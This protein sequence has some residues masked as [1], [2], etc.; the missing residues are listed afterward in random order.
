MNFFEVFWL[1]LVE[2]VT[3][4]LPVSSTGH[5][6]LLSSFFGIQE[7]GFV[8]AFNI[9]IQFGAILAVV[10]LYWRRFLPIRWQFYKKLVIAVLPAVVI[11]FVFKNQVDDLL[12]SS[13]L[14]AVTFIL[15][16][17]VLIW[18]DSK[19]KDDHNNQLQIDDLHWKQ[20][21]ILGFVQCLAMIPGTSRSGATIIGGL[22][23]GLS[24]KAAAEFSFF[25]AVPTLAGAALLKTLKIAKT[26]DSSQLQYLGVGLVLS[27]VFALIA[28]KVL[29]EMVSRFGYRHFGYYRI[30]LGLVILYVAFA[31]T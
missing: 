15:G 5:L 10:A 27:F 3:E 22:F 4:F 13:T 21:L 23:L 2:G 29:I 12:E 1:S 24:R 19:F 16:G 25:L 11:G 14:V 28:V 20:C 26:I 17:F 9:I 31:K 8:K 6:I 18:S 30:A 7:E